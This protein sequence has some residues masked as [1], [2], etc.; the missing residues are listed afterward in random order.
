[1]LQKYFLSRADYYVIK[2]E[3]LQPEGK[4]KITVNEVVVT[5][6]SRLN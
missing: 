4:V 1:M 3:P 6:D 5:I 2:R